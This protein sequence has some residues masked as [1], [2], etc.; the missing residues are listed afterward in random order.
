MGVCTRIWCL[1]RSRC[2]PRDIFGSNVKSC[3]GSL[4]VHRNCSHRHGAN[5]RARER[6]RESTFQPGGLFSD[7]GNN[8][9]C[10][11]DLE[12][13][14]LLASRISSI[15]FVSIL[16]NEKKVFMLV[17]ENNFHSFFRGS[18][19]ISWNIVRACV[20][21]ENKTSDRSHRNSC[22]LVMFHFVF[23]VSR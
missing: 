19:N 11:R 14:S 9:E 5:E 7:C 18:F 23:L 13:C 12:H 6:K 10:L 15:L 22:Q 1:K 21:Y 16:W 8:S 4:Y 2:S 20:W 3:L 17:W